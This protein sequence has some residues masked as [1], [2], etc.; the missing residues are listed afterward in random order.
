M[1]SKAAP[2]GIHIKKLLPLIAIAMAAILGFIFLRDFLSF[3]ALRDNRAVLEEWRD[4]NYLL[5]ALTFIFVYLLVV[6]FSLPGAAI[7]TLTGG[8]LFALFPGVLFVVTGATMGAIAIFLAAKTG[9]GDSLHAKLHGGL[10]KK[11]EAGLHEN[12]ISY[13]FLLRL[14]PVVPFFIANLAPAFLGVSLRN[15]AVTTFLG[16][17]PGSLVYTSVGAGLGEVFDR[18]ETPNLGIIFE[19]HILGPILGLC[20]LAVLP[21][22][23]K[24]FSKKA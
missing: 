20:A 24:K 17:M 10:F 7:L 16:I 4:A 6:A 13:L 23:I 1:M 21:I 19:P 5:A 3:E 9:L 15:F 22:V 11:I 14:V 8:F 2:L 12:E 18:R